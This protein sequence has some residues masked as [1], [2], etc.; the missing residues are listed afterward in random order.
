MKSF[1]LA[2]LYICFAGTLSAQVK[3]SLVVGTIDVIKDPRL[4]LLIKEQYRINSDG[5]LGS[6]A[7]KGYRLMILNTNDRNYAMKVR[8]QLLQHFPD[9]K[10]YMVYQ[11]PYVKLKFGNFLEKTD[12]DKYK[13]LIKKGN[14]VSTNIYLVPETIEVKQNKNKNNIDE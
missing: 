12:A 13:L 4:D 1:L 14:I 7:A 2:G 6:K 8:A 3:D 9:Q 11:A 10:V 5:Q